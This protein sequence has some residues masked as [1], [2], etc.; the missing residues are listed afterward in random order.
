M[1]RLGQQFLARSGLAGDQ[2]RN[3]LANDLAYLGDDVGHLRVASVQIAEPR[4]R[5]GGSGR[6]RRT[7]SVR[8]RLAARLVRPSAVSE[9]GAPKL[10]VR[11]DNCTGVQV[12]R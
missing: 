8:P 12:Q 2:D 11:A 9:H 6:F 10:D 4:K 5:S 1:Y 7:E 3:V